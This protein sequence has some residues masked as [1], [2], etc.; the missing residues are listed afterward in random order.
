MTRTSLRSARLVVT[1]AL[2]ALAVGC[3][4]G[5]CAPQTTATEQIEGDTS[6]G[7]GDPVGTSAHPR[8]SVSMKADYS[9][10][11]S[12]RSA[13]LTDCPAV[14]PGDNDTPELAAGLDCDGDGGI[15]AYATPST[16]KVALKR[17]TFIE[18]GGATVDVVPDSGTLA[19]AQ[20]VDLT[21]EIEL[22]TDELVP[23]T[24]AAYEAEIY[25]IEIV[26][27]LYDPGDPQTLRI[28]MSDDDFAAEGFLGHH[29]GDITLVS[30]AG[31]ELG[32]VTTAQRWEI[33]TLLAQRGDTN[34][35]GGTDPQTGHLRGLYGDTSL[36]DS[37]PLM[38]GSGQD[39]FIWRRPLGL[40]LAESDARVTFTF[41]AS[42][43]WFFEDYDAD[44]RFNPCESLDGCAEGASWSPLIEA[45]TVQIDSTSTEP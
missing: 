38:Q 33:V 40:T 9:G 41:D 15:V 30:S 16:F 44:G 13:S 31:E 1:C 10:A 43:V 5:G 29:Q 24:Y 6:I 21:G 35:G 14:L 19:A 20:V 7:D 32:F 25:Y 39:T 34:G 11:Q 42:N 36:W 4:F 17:L 12:G 27:P 3:L 8:V 22:A 2:A 26:M 28:Y 37:Q 23:G 45:P 18:Q